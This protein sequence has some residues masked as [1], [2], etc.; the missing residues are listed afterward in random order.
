MYFAGWTLACLFVNRLADIY[1]RKWPVL[2]SI[3]LQLPII[4][5][6]CLSTSLDFTIAVYFFFGMMAVGRANLSYLLLMELIPEA[7]RTVVGTMIFILDSC[8]L[9][10][11]SFI[12]RFVTKQWYP[13]QIFT[14]SINLVAL[15]GM[16]FIP[17]S[18]RFLVEAKRYNEARAVISLI[19]R[20][21]K[22][23][24]K[25]TEK[26]DHEVKES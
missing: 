14:M 6:A 12:L 8:T 26:F 13:F 17:E 4:L 16:F 19:S 15:I 11:S 20:V 5:A 10:L 2:I 18:P 23:G 21:N 25:F 3:G 22:T 1:G 7:N 24:G 9:I